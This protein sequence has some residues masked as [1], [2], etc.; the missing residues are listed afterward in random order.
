MIK[1]GSGILLHIS[2]L[3]SPY[4]IG[5]VGP[6]AYAFI[7]YLSEN[8]QSFWQIL[9]FTLTDQIYGNSPYS[10]MSAFAGNTLFI[11]PAFMVRDGFLEENDLEPLPVF[12]NER[13][14]YT[15]VSEYKERLFS[16]AHQL[17]IK[18]KKNPRYEAFCKEHAFWLEDFALFAVLKNHHKGKE[19]AQWPA[20][21]RERNPTALETCT[22]QLR[23]KIEK[24]KFLQYLFF[25]QWRSLKQYSAEKQVQIIGDIPIYVNYDSVDVWTHPEIFKLSK[26]KKPLFVAGVPP[27]YFSQTG[28]L[29]GNP[30]YEWK[31]LKKTGYS[32]WL[33]RLKHTLNLC[34]VLRIDHF[35]GFVAYWQV[36]AT[37][38]TAVNGKW[39]DG[40]GEHFFEMLR[41]Q[42]P[43]LPIIAEDLGIITPDVEALIQKLDLPG[44][45]V[46]LF[47]FD[48]DSAR[49]P[50]VLHNHIK[51]CVV[52]T[53]THDNNTARG[54]FEREATPE[55]KERIFRYLGRSLSAQ[56]IHVE[57]MRMALMSVA[58]A[59]IIPMQ[60]V[61]G[62]DQNARMNIPGTVGTNWQWRLTPD[63]RSLSMST[64]LLEM[65]QLYGRT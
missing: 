55:A 9:P 15:K 60:D 2:S 21:I 5:D 48:G 39:Q 56:E 61:L 57:F 53:G 24:E 3:P 32:W 62:L 4:G 37:E 30:V 65:T 22:T 23:N 7:D 27:D 16:R 14:D 36:P 45:K 12:E 18:R 64:P 10:S 59:A 25:T 6:N 43:S 8:K 44:M 50:Y 29:W 20:E 31:A 35:R 58:D 33:S 38:T 34:D 17:F 19:W 13:V 42:M 11:S 51:N 47:A 28:Q 46:L 1:R 49:H 63:Y 52:Y 54:W 26:D 41:K 40:P